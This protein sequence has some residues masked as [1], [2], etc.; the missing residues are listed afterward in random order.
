MALPQAKLACVFPKMPLTVWNCAQLAAVD[1][2][3]YDAS[4]AAFAELSHIICRY[5]VVETNY[6]KRARSETDFESRLVELYTSILECEAA[7]VRQFCRHIFGAYP[8]C[9]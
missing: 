9:F 6:R 1:M 5:A 4:L 3:Q 2:E 7:L 8:D